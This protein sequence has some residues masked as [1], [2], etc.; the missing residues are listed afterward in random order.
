MLSRGLNTAKAVE[1]SAYGA[2]WSGA[3]GDREDTVARLVAFRRTS[4]CLERDKA[5]SARPCLICTW[6]LP[7]HGSLEAVMAWGRRPCCIWSV[8]LRFAQHLHC[9][10][11]ETGKKQRRSGVLTCRVAVVGC[12]SSR[13]RDQSRSSFSSCFAGSSCF[14][15]S[16]GSSVN[17][18]T[19]SGSLVVRF[20]STYLSA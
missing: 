13:L 15:P 11:S 18:M 3:A 2:E 5:S 14:S 4:C 12:R 9:T 7:L 6:A 8:V 10:S 20:L 16:F 1:R 17:M 19:R